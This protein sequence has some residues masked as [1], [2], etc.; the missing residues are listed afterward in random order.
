[1]NVFLRGILASIPAGVAVLGRALDV[2]AWNHRCEDLWGL[3]ADKVA[4]KRFVDLDIG[5][6]VQALRAPIELA[7]AGKDGE[8]PVT[9]QATNRRGR[10]I[11]CTVT[12]MPLNAADAEVVGVI[13][14]MDAQGDGVRG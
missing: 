10:D 4:G 1:V 14:M 7:L 6:P 8:S 11:H 9:L 13:V 12:C 2:Q 5:L 3:R